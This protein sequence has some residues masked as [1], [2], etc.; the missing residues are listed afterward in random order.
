MEGIQI[1][2]GVECFEKD[3]V[4]YLRLETVARGLGFTTVA[5]SGNEVI[6]WQR[7]FQACYWLRM[8]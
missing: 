7:V 2:Q 1:I 3:G 4:A 6:R 8:A 5:K